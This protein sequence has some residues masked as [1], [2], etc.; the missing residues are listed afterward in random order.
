MDVTQTQV[1]EHELVFTGR[2]GEYMGIW[3]TNLLLTICTL[4]IYSAWAKVRTRKWFY[5]NTRLDGSAFDYLASPL[6]ILRGRLL[7]IGLYLGA[8]LLAKVSATAGGIAV[9]ALFAAVPWAVTRSLRFNARNSAYRGLRFDF[10]GTTG[11]AYL[12][13]PG[14]L[15]VPL[16]L[17]LALPWW[18]AKMMRYLAHHRFGTTDFSTDVSVGAVYAIY[19]KALLML[20]ALIVLLITP[21]VL[22]GQFP[23][24]ETLAAMLSTPGDKK[25][26]EAFGVIAAIG[27][28]LL[29]FVVFLLLAPYLD[30]RQTNLLWHG[31][32]LGDVG[33][34]CRLRARDLLV[35]RLTN[36]LIVVCT[37]GI[38]WPWTQVRNA[39]YRLSRMKVLGAVDKFIGAQIRDGG[40]F[41]E[42]A[43]ELLNI[44]IAL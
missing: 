2:A 14:L 29:A 41:G 28:Y 13:F 40:A 3:W 32:R 39:R 26:A 37:L 16:S 22:L 9:L 33:F 30:S 38:A 24:S 19:G 11:S 17:G 31:R 5:G 1:P 10:V 44:D 12:L 15:L 35:L 23:G 43:G 36:V 27:I 18:R 7:F 25:A 20:L 4:G 21:F 6:A 8:V 42:E 34:A